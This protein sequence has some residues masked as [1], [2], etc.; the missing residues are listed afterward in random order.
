MKKIIA[1]IKKQV[2]KGWSPWVTKT[3]VGIKKEKKF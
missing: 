3:S 1:W 2:K